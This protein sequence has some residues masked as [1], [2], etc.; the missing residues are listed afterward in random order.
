MGRILL[1]AGT[2]C[3]HIYRPSLFYIIQA[4]SIGYVWFPAAIATWSNT[5]TVLMSSIPIRGD[6]CFQC[7]RRLSIGMFAAKREQPPVDDL[8][9]IAVQD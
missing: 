3:R 9:V 6:V 5:Y 7:C 2:A 1:M 4:S 8:L